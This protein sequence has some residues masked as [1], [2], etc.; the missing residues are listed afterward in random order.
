M[1]GLSGDVG[2]GGVQ[3]AVDDLKGQLDAGAA[4]Y[5]TALTRPLS[6]LKNS[7]NAMYLYM[8]NPTSETTVDIKKQTVIQWLG[9]KSFVPATYKN[10]I[11]AM[12]KHLE[13]LEVKTVISFLSE[14]ETKAQ[15]PE[16]LPS[17]VKELHLPID[18][19]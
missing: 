9:A 19:D 10:S 11:T 14:L 4:A 8:V 6:T 13:S 18:V 2:K 15:A 12:S 5:Q 16:R 1:A 7:G 17:G 3:Q